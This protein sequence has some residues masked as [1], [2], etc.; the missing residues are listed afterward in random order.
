MGDNPSL[1]HTLVLH[2]LVLHERLHRPLLPGP[3]KQLGVDA[4]REVLWC[5]FSSQFTL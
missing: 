4:E 5:L 3:W 1:L 2:T